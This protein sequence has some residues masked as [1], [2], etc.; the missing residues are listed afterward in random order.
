MVYIQDRFC[1]KTVSRMT[2]TKN[3]Q[4]RVKPWPQITKGTELPTDVVTPFSTRP[5]ELRQEV[6]VCAWAQGSRTR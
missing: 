2:V 6:W 4:R 1:Y 3:G 5:G